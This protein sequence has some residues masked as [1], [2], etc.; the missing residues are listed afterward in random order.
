MKALLKRIFRRHSPRLPLPS[1]LVY[2][3]PSWLH[4]KGREAVFTLIHD[5]NH[6]GNPES[7]SGP[8]STYA[9]TASI[10]HE[11]PRLWKMLGTRSLLDA[12]CGDY[13]WFRAIPIQDRPPCYT[14]GDIVQAL[15]DNNQ[16]QFGNAGTRFIHL[17][18]V[19]DP[20]PESDF[21]LCRDCLFHLGQ[22]DILATLRNFAHSRIPYLCTSTF[23]DC[24]ENRDT[25]AGGYRPLNLQRAPFNLPEP[26][27][28]I[29]DWIEGF[30]PRHLALW[31]RE[32]VL[33]SQAGASLDS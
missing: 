4:G 14:G 7:L 29:R 32:A 11:L 5:H 2:H 25:V 3:P 9:Y 22:A 10:R 16:R 26:I 21:W 12:P 24:Q 30:T 20:L 18:I 13:H 31:T 8:G 1:S 33:A 17:D 28:L 27:H 19:S 6:W 15:I 23:P